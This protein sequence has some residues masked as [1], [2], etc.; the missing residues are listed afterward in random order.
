MDRRRPVSAAR[1]P[2][3]VA[4]PARLPTQF[5]IPAM[6]P[7]GHFVGMPTRSLH[8]RGAGA[9]GDNFRMAG[10]TS[11]TSDRKTAKKQYELEA[12]RYILISN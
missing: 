12:N 6:S 7:H 10:D 3:S 5:G 2:C 9:P 1:R 8:A 11:R 4:A